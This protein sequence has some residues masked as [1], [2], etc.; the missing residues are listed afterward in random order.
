MVDW[1]KGWPAVRLLK[2]KH[3][4]WVW[5]RVRKEWWRDPRPDDVIEMRAGCA[6]TP[7]SLSEPIVLVARI[8]IDDIPQ[9]GWEGGG[10]AIV[11]AVVE[12]THWFQP[13]SSK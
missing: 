8:R 1:T 10:A 2:I 7:R 5:C 13:S 6:K 9:N 3:P 11:R 4:E 12:P